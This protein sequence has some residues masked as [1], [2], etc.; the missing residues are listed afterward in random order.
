M[1]KESVS[2]ARRTVT[3]VLEELE[4]L[5]EI[6]LRRE[7]M[8]KAYLD[9]KPRTCGTEGCR[10][11]RGEKHPAWVVR[12]PQGGSSSNRSIP[13]RTYEELKPLA[14]EYRRFRQ[15]LAGWRRLVREADRALREIEAGRLL[16]PQDELEKRHGE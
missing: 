16:D 2:Q 13:K 10:C 9:A 15:A 8:L 4:A 7:P 6:L 3:R 5:R 12:I 14:A 1:A 11:A